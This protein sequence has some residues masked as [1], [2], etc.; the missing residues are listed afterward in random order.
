MFHVSLGRI[1]SVKLF[2]LNQIA[3]TVPSIWITQKAYSD[4]CGDNWKVY[5]YSFMKQTCNLQMGIAIQGASY[6]FKR[7]SEGTV[8]PVLTF[9]DFLK[10]LD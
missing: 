6:V 1:L 9:F 8:R 10:F 2:L 3:G 4:Y 7:L 5:E